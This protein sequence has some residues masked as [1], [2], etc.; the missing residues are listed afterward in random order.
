MVTVSAKGPALRVL[1][2]MKTC[3]CTITRWGDAAVLKR[4]NSLQGRERSAASGSIL[5]N[6]E[7]MEQWNDLKLVWWH[8]AVDRNM[9]VTT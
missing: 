1:T 7:L 3:R 6:I 2:S 9:G 8:M 5:I 4:L